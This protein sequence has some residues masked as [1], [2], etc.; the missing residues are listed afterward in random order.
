MLAALTEKGL[1]LAEWRL[2]KFWQCE[3]VKNQTAFSIHL[4]NNEDKKESNEMK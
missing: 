4:L 2:S 3:N 1:T